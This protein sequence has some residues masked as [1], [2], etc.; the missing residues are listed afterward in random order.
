MTILDQLTARPWFVATVL[1]IVA[2]IASVLVQV[3]FPAAITTTLGTGLLAIAA[4]IAALTSIGLLVQGRV[5]SWEFVMAMLILAFT[6]R[7]LV[8]Q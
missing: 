2:F 4:G 3:V 6:V 7:L 5:R 1:A 8:Y